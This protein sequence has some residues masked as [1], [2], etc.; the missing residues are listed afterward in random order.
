MV[1]IL[2][3][4]VEGPDCM[5]RYHFRR[6]DGNI[7]PLIDFLIVVLHLCKRETGEGVTGGSYDYRSESGR[8][9]YLSSNKR[10]RYK[11]RTPR[12]LSKIVIQTPIRSLRRR[13]LEDPL[14]L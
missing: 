2:C 7:S 12:T 9:V 13:L 4:S 14:H 5:T 8:F 3:S 6:C 11:D 1:S 10:S